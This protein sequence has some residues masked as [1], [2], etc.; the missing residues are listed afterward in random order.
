MHS[1][2]KYANYGILVAV[3]IMF[4]G[5][6]IFRNAGDGAIQAVTVAAFIGAFATHDFFEQRAHRRRSHDR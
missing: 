1:H 3:I 6:F 4:G 2:I 5:G